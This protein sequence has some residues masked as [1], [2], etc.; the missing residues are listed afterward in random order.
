MARA[1][2]F[3]PLL[4]DNAAA[5]IADTVYRVLAV[6]DK[7]GSGLVNKD[8]IREVILSLGEE[9]S[10][11]ELDDM[12]TSVDKDEDGFMDFEGEFELAVFFIVRTQ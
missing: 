7:E 5:T 11:K 1:S 4:A 10:D 3:P 9:V 8:H 12:M 6:F 2:S